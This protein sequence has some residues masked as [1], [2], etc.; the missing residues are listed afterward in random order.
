[1]WHCLFLCS[2]FR[3]V[4]KGEHLQGMEGLQLVKVL[5]LTL[6]LCRER[7]VSRPVRLRTGWKLLFQ[8]YSDRQVFSLHHRS[9]FHPAPYQWAPGVM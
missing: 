6:G 8:Y 3:G 2:V 9:G 7:S 4:G 1:M 5:S